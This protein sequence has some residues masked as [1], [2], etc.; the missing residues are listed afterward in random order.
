[1]RNAETLLGLVVLGLVLGGALWVRGRGH[2][3]SPRASGGGASREAMRADSAA[4]PAPAAVTQAAIPDVTLADGSV[5]VGDAR[6]AFSITPRPPVA[7]TKERVRVR[8]ESPGTVRA[9]DGGRITFEMAMPMGEHRYTLVPGADGWQEAEIVLPACASG[10]SRWYAQ[11]EG[12]V[13]GRPAAAR[14][15]LDLARPAAA[16]EDEP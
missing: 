6:I 8:V 11:V 16:T 4:G 10:N 5:D 1:M 2:L 7:L 12:A 9:L 14:F 15:R 13:A 3:P